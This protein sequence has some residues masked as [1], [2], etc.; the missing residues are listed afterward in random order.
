MRRF[1]TG[2]VAAT[3]LTVL[4]A[5]GTTAQEEYPPGTDEPTVLPTSV[6]RPTGGATPGTEEPEAGAEAEVEDLVL[7]RTGTDSAALAALAVGAVA[8][9][10]GAVAYGR[11]RQG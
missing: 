11:R 1:L 6:E 9:G 10:G 5:G 3:L 7:Q 2:A 4:P 8:L